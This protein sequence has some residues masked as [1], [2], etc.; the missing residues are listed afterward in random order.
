MAIWAEGQNAKD[1]TGGFGIE[2]LHFNY[3]YLTCEKKS[4]PCLDIGILLSS[5]KAA[6]KLKIWVPF[7]LEPKDIS[8]L[9][10]NL[11]DAALLGAVFN[12]EYR[13]DSIEGKARFVHLVE[14]GGRQKK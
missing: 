5:F 2:K 6:E 4:V 11:K 10:S 3:W 9:A 14:S 1:D 13:V 12:D 7:K 8:D